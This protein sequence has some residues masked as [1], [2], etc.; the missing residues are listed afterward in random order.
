MSKHCQETPS[1][2]VEVFI[3][4]VA[5]FL[6]VFKIEHVK[7]NSG[8]PVSDADIHRCL[9]DPVQRYDADLHVDFAGPYKG[10]KYQGLKY[11]Q[12]Q[13]A[14]H[15][16][17]IRDLCGSGLQSNSCSPHVWVCAEFDRTQSYRRSNAQLPIN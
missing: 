3:F 8:C 2:E 11:F 4:H 1:Y 9:L 17:A 14:H 16:K 10:L 15:G 5:K 12:V 7:R 6:S 13:L